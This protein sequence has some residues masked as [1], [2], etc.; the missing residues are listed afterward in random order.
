METYRR[1]RIVTI[2]KMHAF[3]A[4]VFIAS[5]VML[6]LYAGTDKECSMNYLSITQ[7]SQGMQLLFG[8][9][10]LRAIVQ[11]SVIKWCKAEWL[12]SMYSAFAVYIVL[13]EWVAIALWTVFGVYLISSDAGVACRSQHPDAV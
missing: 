5:I 7:W 11:I 12:T 3:F 2:V 8:I 1:Q 13:F 4:L 10:I 6:E 9:Q